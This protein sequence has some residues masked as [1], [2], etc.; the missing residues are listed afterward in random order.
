MDGFSV[1]TRLTAAD[2]KALSVASS[3]RTQGRGWRGAAVVIGLPALIWAL[4]VGLMHFVHSP[5]ES[6]W[7]AIG[8]VVGY[9]AVALLIRIVRS[10]HKPVADGNFL[11][12][13]HYDFSP[14][15]IRIR[16][17]NSD[18]IWSWGGVR[19][20]ALSGEH[21]FIWVD[22]ITAFLVPVRDLPGDLNGEQAQISLREMQA[23]VGGQQEGPQ[24]GAVVAPGGFPGTES[25]PRPART[26]GRSLVALVRWLTLR[27]FERGAL[28]APDVAIVLVSLSCLALVIGLDH[29]AVGPKAEFSWYST[30]TLAVDVLGVMAIGWILWRAADPQPAWRTVLF[31]VAALTLVAVPLRWGIGQLESNS[32]QLAAVWILVIVLSI[33]LARAL[34]V[35]TGY[36]QYRAVALG[37]LPASIERPSARQSA[38]SYPERC[39]HACPPRRA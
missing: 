12:E 26:V 8:V 22:S 18:S 28:A 27:P 20:I 36:R 23:R 13:W 4:F 5:V 24:L 10:W 21:L 29:V 31:M 38:H 37:M 3:R 7:L 19:E 9:G 6:N 34:R 39:Y 14:L 30:P 17:K 16:R 1:N 33:Y 25:A 32:L 15:G 2:W 35:V 11:G